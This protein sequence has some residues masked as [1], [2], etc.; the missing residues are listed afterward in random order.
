MTNRRVMIGKRNVG[1]YGAW[2]TKP[3]ADAFST[4]ATD[5][6]LDTNTPNA[7]T[8]LSGSI[9][10]NSTG[11]SLFSSVHLGSLTYGGYTADVYK[12]VHGCLYAHGLGYAPMVWSDALPGGYGGISGGIGGGYFGTTTN[13][14]TYCYGSLAPPGYDGPFVYA[15][16]D[17]TYVGI[18]ILGYWQASNNYGGTTRTYPLPTS[19]F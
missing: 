1:E 17:A 2:V 10:A 15:Y 18:A 5:F 14:C 6:L 19:S 7:W 8:V 16:S 12:M 13:P 11:F 4:T 3:L 9:I